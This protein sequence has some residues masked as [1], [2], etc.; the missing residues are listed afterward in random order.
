[1]LAAA[2]GAGLAGIIVVTRRTVVS[3][4]NALED[5]DVDGDA[6]TFPREPRRPPDRS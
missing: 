1:M 3:A 2:G 5:L 6:P 4:R